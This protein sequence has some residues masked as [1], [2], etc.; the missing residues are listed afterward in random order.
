TLYGTINFTDNLIYGNSALMF[1]G[2][3]HSYQATAQITN[4]TIVGNTLTQ[5]IKPS[6]YSFASYGGGLFIDALIPQSGHVRIANTLV[7]GTPVASLGVGGGLDSNSTFPFVGYTDLWS[8]LQLP[9]TQSN[10]GGDYTEAQVLGSGNNS[11]Q[12]PRFV[13]APL[14]AD[15]SVA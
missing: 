3:L 11:S 9:S 6:G 12:D 13:R 7:T 1:G 8:N 14:F 4:N 5:T 10:V 15:V 2:G